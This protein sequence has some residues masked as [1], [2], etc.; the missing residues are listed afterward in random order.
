MLRGLFVLGT[1]LGV[2]VLV[3]I[4]FALWGQPGGSAVEIAAGLSG[5]LALTLLF[6]A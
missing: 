4:G 6:K 1:C 5:A 3:L 2:F